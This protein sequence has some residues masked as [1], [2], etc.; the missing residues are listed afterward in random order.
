[1]NEINP[2]TRLYTD[3]INILNSMTIKYSVKA[4]EFETMESKSKG[5]RYINALMKKDVF[6]MYDD[7][8]VQEYIDSGVTDENLIRQYR[9]NRFIVPVSIQK[10]LIALRR[11]REIRD[12]EEQNNYYRM[13]NGYPDIEDTDFVYV[14]K[15][16]CEKYDIPE[17]LPI[18]KISD[19]MGDFY[20]TLLE[21]EG[22]LDEVAKEHSDK[23]YLKH[24][25]SKRISIQYA[26]N[27]KNFAILSINQEEIMESTYREFIR[28]Y[29]KARLYFISTAYNYQ[30]RTLIPY[31]DNFIALC[32]FIMAIQQVS[33]RSIANATQREFYDEYMVQ[34]L[35]ETYGVPYFSK[36]DS[37]T[38][39]QI[40]QNL[41]LLVQNKATN[42]VVLDIASI[43]GFNDISIYQYF[44]VKKQKFDKNGRPIIAKKKRVNPSTGKEE[45]VYDQKAMKSVYFQKVDFDEENVK[46]A[47]IDSV[48]R[49]EYS[50][51]TYYDPYCWEDDEL[52]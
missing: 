52:N 3:I 26:R 21:G 47:L 48:N 16:Y 49:A 12:Y 25:G 50:D 13:L 19:T 28:S 42:K 10:K 43:L 11:D 30:F 15:E 18:H 4:D 23:E 46:D 38:Q 36:I 14:S 17:D 8:T 22:Y 5:D 45:E 40:V 37:V 6:T 29:E 41:N 34:L 24:L 9:E 27:A 7:Y 51:I 32:I 39:K 31:Y 33:V 44:L 35:Y 1:M 2:I 20:I